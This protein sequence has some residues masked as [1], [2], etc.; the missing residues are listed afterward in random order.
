MTTAASP[1]EITSGGPLRAIERALHM[2]HGDTRDWIRRAA[3]CLLIV[4]VPVLV[5]GVGLRIF[6]RHWPPG[7]LELQPHA[8]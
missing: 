7:V 4:Y 3:V 8:S 6:A 5:V 2:T 1:Y